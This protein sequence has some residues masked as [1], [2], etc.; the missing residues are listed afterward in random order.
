M[1]ISPNVRVVEV[2]ETDPMRPRSTNIYVVGQDQVL[3]IDSGE[4][5]DKFKWMIRGYLAAVE[6]SEIAVAGITH[7]HFDHSGNLKD[8]QENL[9]AEIL[10]P[11][12]GVD[13][14]G[15][16]LPATGV[17]K[18]ED[19]RTIDL[20]G[21]LQVQVLATPGHSVDSIC[22]YIEDD[23]VLFTGD[24]V[25][26]VGTTTVHDLADYRASL[27]RLADLPNLKLICPGHG[28]LVRDARDRLRTYIT[29]R[30]TREEQIVAV[31]QNSGPMSS[32]D[33]MLR[34]YTDIDKKLRR[35]A[36]GNVRAHLKQLEREGRIRNLVG[37]RRTTTLFSGVG[38][39]ALGRTR[40]E[41]VR[42]AK[43][44]EEDDRRRALAQQE[45]PPDEE[46]AEPPRYELTDINQ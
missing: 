5:I 7:H 8:L 39:K 27:R 16:R 42:R 4:A 30:D 33:I 43:K 14:L 9:H 41:I 6:R 40:G 38:E 15:D 12:N 25:L 1:Q 37:K 29:H 20:G 22:Y 21:G 10:V 3:T 19:G 13:L 24:T 18:L 28:P 23:G 36:E 44:I 17:D 26:G 2:P 35:A 45:N 31:L 32:W 46:W 11:A 34:L